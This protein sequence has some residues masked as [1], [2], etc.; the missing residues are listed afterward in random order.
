MQP[1]SGRSV[2]VDGVW[3]RRGD[4]HAPSIRSKWLGLTNSRPYEQVDEEIHCCVVT[5]HSKRW[6]VAASE[7]EIS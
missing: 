5:E 3:Q 4:G 6:E 1:L 2:L 7:V